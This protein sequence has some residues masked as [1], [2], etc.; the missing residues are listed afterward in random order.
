MHLGLKRPIYFH[1][2]FSV[3]LLA[4]LRT[5]PGSLPEDEKHVKQSPGTSYSTQ[6]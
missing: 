6:G 3:P 2:F 1:L 4:A 5:R